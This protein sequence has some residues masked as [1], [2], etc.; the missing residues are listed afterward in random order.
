MWDALNS[1]FVDSGGPRYDHL[2]KHQIFVQRSPGVI[3]IVEKI[4][5]TFIK[6]CS[7]NENRDLFH[8]VPGSFGSLGICTR[9]KILCIKAKSHVLVHCKRHHSHARCVEYMGDIQDACLQRARNKALE[10]T[11]NFLLARL[12]L[13][14]EIKPKLDFMEG[15]GYSSNEFVS[16]LGGFVDQEEVKFLEQVHL[17][18]ES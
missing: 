11:N 18:A 3:T 1:I 8:A 6:W 16:L 14:N 12:S 15:L 5:D 7:R 4:V 9:A 17:V 10:T 13:E 2:T